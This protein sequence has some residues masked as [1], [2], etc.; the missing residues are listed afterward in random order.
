MGPASPAG[1]PTHASIVYYT[2]RWQL[3]WGCLT[4]TFLKFSIPWRAQS[5]GPAS[6]ENQ[7]GFAQSRVRVEARA[8]AVAAKYT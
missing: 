4:Q 5:E 2:L 8:A 7:S 3:D 1:G 6:V